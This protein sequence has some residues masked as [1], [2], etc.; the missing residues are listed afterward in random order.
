MSDRST[1]A[2]TMLGAN[3]PEIGF[4][5]GEEWWFVGDLTPKRP[6]AVTVVSDRLVF[7]PRL[8]T[9]A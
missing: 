1:T 5:N 8:T 3:P 6:D 9:V 2:E 7:K 4:W